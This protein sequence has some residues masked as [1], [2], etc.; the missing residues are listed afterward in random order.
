MDIKDIYKALKPLRGR[1]HLNIAIRV[2]LSGLAAAGVVSLALALAAL[3]IPVP[4]L[5]KTI[6][7]IYAFILMLS[8]AVS[9]ILRPGNLK[10]VKVGD[11][12]G[13]KERLITAFQFR[14]DYSPL[15]RIQRY[16][17]LK[18]VQGVNFKQLYP[19]RLPKREGMI[20]IALAFL[21][22]LSFTIPAGAREKAAGFE[23]VSDEVRKQAEKLENERKELRK[24]SDLS[25]EKLKEIDKKIDGLLKELKGSKTEGQALKALSRTRHELEKLKNKALDEEMRKLAERLAQNPVTKDFGSALKSGNMEDIKQKIESLNEALKNLDAEGKE[26][27]AE[28]IN[29]TFSKL[30]SSNEN[31]A[32]AMQQLENEIINQ[33]TDSIDEARRE[34]DGQGGGSRRFAQEAGQGNQQGNGGKGNGTGQGE[35]NGQGQGIGQGGK[36]QGGGGGAGDGTTNKDAGYGGEDSGSASRQPGQKEVRDYESIYVPDRLGD[37]GNA[38]QVK[39]D[40]NRSGT[41][42]WRE[43]ANVPVERGNTVPYNEV[44]EDYK[45]E[46][47]KSIAEAPIPPVMKDIVRDYFTSLE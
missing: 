14:E 23:K 10:L 39:G 38:S 9:L 34:I 37:G 31:L 26:K 30:A 6:V 13:L 33:V 21:I 32:D 46:A 19:L 36:G 5:L 28:E 35:G 7:L 15:V 4:Y 25:T 18:A 3:F 20:S 40:M 16:D 2:L 22:A 43:A 42:E 1:I 47:V 41:S 11:S 12:L 24:K 8:L 29:T 45:N 27:L 44:L 17:A